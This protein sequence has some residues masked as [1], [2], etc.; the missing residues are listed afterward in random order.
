MALCAPLL[1]LQDPSEL[2]PLVL[3][4]KPASLLFHS[5]TIK[6]STDFFYHSLRPIMPPFSV[7]NK[8]SVLGVHVRALCFM[9]CLYPWSKH[10]S[11]IAGTYSEDNGLLL[12]W[13][14]QAAPSGHGHVVLGENAGGLKW[15]PGLL[16]SL[17]APR[18]PVPRDR[19]R[20]QCGWSLWRTQWAVRP[21]A[22]AGDRHPQWW[23]RRPLVCATTAAGLTA[24]HGT[25]ASDG[26][27]VGGAQV[28]GWRAD[29][30][31]AQRFRA[32][33]ENRA[34]SGAAGRRGVPAGAH[35]APWLPSPLGLRAAV[36]AGMGARPGACR[37]TAER[38]AGHVGL[39]G[40][41]LWRPRP[42]P[43]TGLSQRGE[44]PPAGS[45]LL[46]RAGAG[47]GK[48]KRN[49]AVCLRVRGSS[50]V[51]ILQRCWGF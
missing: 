35:A 9:S 50:Q 15:L 3:S 26:G 22:G 1:P 24:C 5:L 27:P 7:L 44:A 49:E 18:R 16:D 33:T 34:W 25:R 47:E 23:G 32:A 37:N 41:Q 38:P 46:G 2:P 39:R 31:R 4:G 36:E 21:V 12:Y 43:C 17:V 51:F 29:H 40:A 10:E 45:P 42:A 19:G 8:F 6:I 28:P 11:Q 30:M 48:G 14:A 20:R 13:L